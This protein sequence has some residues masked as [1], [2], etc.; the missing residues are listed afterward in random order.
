MSTSV[1]IG[2]LN[3]SSPHLLQCVG[4]YMCVGHIALDRESLRMRLVWNFKGTFIR[5]ERDISH[6]LEVPR[7]MMMSEERC[8]A[9]GLASA[10]RVPGVWDSLAA[11]NEF[12]FNQ[13]SS[14]QTVWF[15]C[16]SLLGRSDSLKAIS[17][18]TH[19]LWDFCYLLNILEHKIQ[20]N[21]CTGT[22]I[23]EPDKKTDHLIK[24]SILLTVKWW[25]SYVYQCSNEH[26]SKYLT[27]IF[28]RI[29]IF[30]EII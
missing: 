20:K 4:V 7:Y 9:E 13:G 29:V 24:I 1:F 12:W 26:V 28:K 16:R 11:L 25:N 15:K 2:L 19:L 18:K 3:N 6:Q 5:P 23:K 10:V 8:S 27:I 17:T 22:R 14:A 30:L 21:S